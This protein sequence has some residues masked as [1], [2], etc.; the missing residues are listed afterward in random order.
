MKIVQI[1]ATCGRG[2]TGVI[3]A[4]ISKMLFEKDIDNRVF[5]AVGSSEEESA[6]KYAQ[7]SEIKLAAA[8]SRIS[9]KY[10][11]TS[12]RITKSLIKELDFFKPDIVHLH[13][14]HSHNC[15]L[16]IFLDYLSEKKIKVVW[17]FHDCWAFTGYCTH[18][19]MSDCGKWRSQCESC[20]QYKHFS[21]LFD[22]SSQL[23]CKKREL[24]SK[25][26]LTVVT[27]SQWL[28]AIVKQSFLSDRRVEVIRNGIDLTVFKPEYSDIRKRYDIP[29][30]KK[31]IL[32]VSFDWS[33]RKGIDVFCELSKRLDKERYQIVL[34][35]ADGASA[36]DLP[37]N[38]IKIPRLSDK[39]ELRQLYSAADV[40]VNPTRED[41]FPT[42][43]M[44]SVACGTP[45]ITSDAGG[46]RETISPETGV[47]VPNS[48][49]EGII[50]AVNEIT[51]SDRYR[52][53][54]CR[55]YANEHFDKHMAYQSYLSLY[56]GLN[57]V[58]AAL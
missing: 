55:N 30:D 53:E 35:G 44:E 27:P 37:K 31:M 14:I 20:P 25:L 24:L 28:G 48:D 26:D 47:V 19:L 1:N 4:D 21:L 13:N 42:V 46:C 43:N 7:D 8:A 54:V 51:G 50:E 52:T 49:I 38:I 15:N 5:Y 45:V 41:T 11:F 10:G 16:S 32:G 29:E 57:K 17:T 22:R 2:S 33:V 34:V 18:F 40:F 58:S 36:A 3:C 12:K 39:A 6:V 23:F 9:G 56:K